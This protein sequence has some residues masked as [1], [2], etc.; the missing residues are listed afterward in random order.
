MNLNNDNLKN[1]QGLE[2]P[3]DFLTI[4]NKELAIGMIGLVL[5]VSFI[6]FGFTGVKVF[7]GTML[8]L[9]LPFYLI[10]DNFDIG[11]GEKVVFSFFIGVG[12]FSTLVYYLGI[13]FN[14]I[15][16]AIVVSFVLL[17]GIG[18]GLKKFG[19]K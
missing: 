13:M 10:F 7:G 9:F 19:K 11:L 5:L 3:K 4:G 17:I 2:N 14:S 8:L 6:L 1:Y 15:K 12:M 18:L 16:T